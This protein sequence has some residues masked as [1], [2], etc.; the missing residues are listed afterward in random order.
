MTCLL[1]QNRSLPVTR[2][3]RDI[4]AFCK[5]EVFIK[6]FRKGVRGRIPEWTGRPPAGTATG[7]CE[8]AGRK[9]SPANRTR[10]VREGS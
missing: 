9:T 2:V 10:N 8:K 3:I 7:R 1:A 6:L 5:S 4:I